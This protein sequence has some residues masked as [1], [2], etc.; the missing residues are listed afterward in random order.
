MTQTSMFRPAAATPRQTCCQFTHDHTD[1]L[2][3]D[4][5]PSPR[6][7]VPGPACGEVAAG[8]QSGSP[9]RLVLQEPLMPG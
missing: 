2:R 9:Q 7:R 5:P 8:S 4:G 1:A 6:H 3:P